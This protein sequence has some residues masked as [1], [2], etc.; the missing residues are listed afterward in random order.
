[1]IYIY[2]YIYINV[3]KNLKFKFKT[4]DSRNKQYKIDVK[5]LSKQYQTLQMKVHPDKYQAKSDEERSISRRHSA[6][7]SHAYHTLR[8][9][10]LRAKYLMELNGREIEEKKKA[11]VPADFLMWILEKQEE[12]EDAQEEDLPA[13]LQEV[14][15]DYFTLMFSISFTS[16]LGVQLVSVIISF[17]N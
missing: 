8:E 10:S 2:I 14:R 4:F 17:N 6:L 3:S 5:A 11:S 12:M 15:V 7:T 16:F 1:M 13:L 9:P